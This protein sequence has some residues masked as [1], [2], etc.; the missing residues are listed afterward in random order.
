MGLAKEQMYEEQER[1]CSAVAGVVCD[2][3]FDDDAI[4]TYVQGNAIANECTY[5]SRGAAEPIAADADE[6]AGLIMEGILT[7]WTDPVEELAYESAEGGYQGQQIDF[8]E[9]L[10]QV[11]DPIATY[12]FQ[13]A[14]R[15][16]TVDHTVAWCKRDYAAPHLDDALTY[17]WQ[18]LS[19][20]VRYD[21]RYF[22]SEKEGSFPEPG[23]AGNA[24][25]ILEHI[26]ELAEEAGLIRWLPE[27]ECLWRVRRHDIG[28]RYNSAADLGTPRPEHSLSSN[29]MSPAG[30]PAFYGAGDLETGKAEVRGSK[31]DHRPEW[32][33]GC[34]ATTEACAILDLVRLDEPPSLFDPERRSFRR[35]LMFFHEFA[36]EISQPLEA[37]NREHIDYVPTQVVAE[38]MRSAFDSE[39]GPIRGIAYRSAQQDGGICVVLFASNEQCIDASPS[40]E[41]LA[42]KIVDTKHGVL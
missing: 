4:R 6:V 39:L 3:C 38:F 2:S 10:E 24:L 11:G 29:R 35:P 13:E 27:G 23:R 33:A 37:D 15:A 19:N 26:G 22:F 7:E 17:D 42:L 41:G 31:P 25:Q 28:K 12:E 21:S 8:D 32:S 30:I 16:G 20:L 40:A 36:S 34:F 18:A 9:V 14:L 1:R 5:C